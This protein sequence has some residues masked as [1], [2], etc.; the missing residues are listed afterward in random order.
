MLPESLMYLVKEKRHDDA[1]K[2]VRRLAP[3]ETITTSTTLILDEPT[4]GDDAPIKAL[5][6]KNRGFT[7]IMFWIA[8]FMCLLM[9]Y[10][11]ASWLPKL[12]IQAGY[13]LGASMLF[14]FALNIGGMI[15]AI[16][17]GVLADR[18]H[19]KPVLTIMFVAGAAALILLG[20][21]SPQAVLYTLIAI[22]GATTIGSQIL[23]YTFVAQYYPTAVRTTAMGWA[24][25]IGRIGAIV[26]PILTGA[27][28]TLELSHQTNFLFI[29]IPGIIAATAIFLVNLNAA[30][31]SKK[32]QEKPVTLDT[33]I[34]T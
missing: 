7:T 26:G 30:V 23:L 15:G 11:L 19:L 8:F 12:M 2:I 21:N 20:Y 28:L 9:V 13:S 22:A 1:K 31:D 10:A 32:I 16:G 5:F 14:L 6:L 3:Q 17:G 24:S 34:A 27:L 4:K 33:P 29:A 25:G 18:F